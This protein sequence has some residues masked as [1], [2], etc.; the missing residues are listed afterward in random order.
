MPYVLISIYFYI[1][2][3]TPSKAFDGEF[4]FASSI[5]L[6]IS[7]RYFAAKNNGFFWLYF[8]LSFSIISQSCLATLWPQRCN[9]SKPKKAGPSK[10]SK[11]RRGVAFLIPMV[12]CKMIMIKK[13]YY[14]QQ[15]NKNTS[16]T[17]KSFF[18]LKTPLVWSLSPTNEN[19][20]RPSN[21]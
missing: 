5:I 1:P 9:S 16:Q 21:F 17:S 18:F 14:V 13:E 11:N 7:L 12:S 4:R 2:K 6:P 10:H 3:N 20:L 19:P 8:F 15:S